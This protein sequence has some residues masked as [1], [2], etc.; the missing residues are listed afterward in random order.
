[1]F[2][3]GL[4]LSKKVVIL[5]GTFDPVHKQHSYI[6]NEAQ[7]QLDCDEKYYLINKCP[8]HKNKTCTSDIDRLNMLQIQ[9]SLD[10]SK[11]ITNE[12]SRGGISYT[13][14]TILE[15]KK[16]HPEWEIYFLIGQDNANTLNSWYQIQNLKNLLTFVIVKRGDI[17]MNKLSSC[18][19]NINVSNYS[20][21]KVRFGN[22]NI[23]SPAVRK[24]ILNK[25]VY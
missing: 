8:P 25:K 1:M 11:I 4:Q 18:Y 14:D 23:V 3:K 13:Y 21:T 5:G 9:A 2:Q 6:L 20:S 24:Y 17:S 19:I 16:Q 12:L 22:Y 7:R 10:N 15:L